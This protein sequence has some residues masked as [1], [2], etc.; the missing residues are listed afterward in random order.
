MEILDSFHEK[1]CKEETANFLSRIFFWWINPLINIG[2]QRFLQE[3][4]LYDIIA[5]E[6]I[7][8]NLQKFNKISS[9]SNTLFRIFFSLYKKEFFLAL[10]FNFI[11]SLLQFAGP[12]CLNQILQFLQENDTSTYVGYIWASIMVICFFLRS[13]FQQHA[14]HYMNRIAQ[15][16]QSSLYGKIYEKLLKLGTSSKKLHDTGKI[17]NMIN[18]DVYAIWNF[19]QF[20]LF[21]L[22]TPIILVL[23]IILIIMQLSWIGAIGI[24]ILLNGFLLQ[25]IAQ[26][27]GSKFRKNMMKQT[28]KRCQAIH[29]FVNGIK[30][31]KYFGWEKIALSR[32]LELRKIESSNIMSQAVL[33]GLTDVISTAFPLII[34]IVVFSIYQIEF[35]DLTPATAYTVLSLFNLI[36]VPLSIVGHLMV[37]YVNA[38]AGMIR[39]QRFINCEE[40]E[41]NFLKNDEK[42]ELKIGDI[43]IENG[44]FFWE[45]IVEKTIDTINPMLFSKNTKTRTLP[46]HDRLIT[47]T[48][49]KVGT[50]KKINLSMKAGEFFAVIGT[51]G[52]G[53]SSLA[54]CLLNEMI[55]T[56]GSLQYAGNIAYVPQ[57]AWLMNATFRENIL[58]YN[59]YDEIKY[60]KILNICKLKNDINMLPGGDLTEIGER[61]VNLSGGQKQ[62]ISLARALYH[63]ADIYIIDDVLSALDAHVG[64]HIYKHV[65]RG[66]LRVKTVIFITHALQYI[67]DADRI[68]VFRNGE[69]CQQGTFSSL[70]QCAFDS[71]FRK[72]SSYQALNNSYLQINSIQSVMKIRCIREKGENIIGGFSLKEEGRTYGLVP[73]RIYKLYLL[74]GGCCLTFTA[75]MMFFW[76]QGARFMNDWWLGVWANDQYF[77]PNENY[78]EIYIGLAVVGSI[79]VYFRSRIFF[80]YTLKIS[81]RFQNNLMNTIFKAPMCWFDE[82]PVG[83]ILSRTTKDQDNLDVNLPMTMQFCL[84]NILKIFGT[85]IIASIAM[86]LFLIPILFSFIIYCYLI[87]KY[88]RSSCEI[89]RIELNSRGPVNSFFSETSEG[90]YVIR[91]FKKE[92]LFFK[93]F[94]EKAE[95]YMVAVQNNMYAARWIGLRTD[96]FGTMLVAA[97][98]YF[99]V[100][101]KDFNTEGSNTSLIGFSM[102]WILLITQ[103]LNF[104]IRLMA[105]TENY[106]SSVEKIDEYINNTP[107]EAD[108]D[109]PKPTQEVWP[110]L[111]II[112]GENLCYKYRENLDYVVKNISFDI[113]S[114]EKIGIVGRTG[115]GKSTLTLGLLRILELAPNEDGI[116]GRILIDGEDI[117]KIGLH[118]LRRKITIIPQ[119]PMLFS[120]TIRS[121]LDPFN[122]YIDGSIEEALIK[123]KMWN[124]LGIEGLNTEVFDGGFNFSLGQKQLICI[125]RALIRKPKLLIMDEATANM[126]E[127]TDFLIQ[128]LIQNEFKETTVLTIAHR[129]NTIINYDRIMVFEQGKIVEFDT[130][131][132]LLET[133]HSV[134]ATLVKENG[135]QFEM[136][137][138]KLARIQNSNE[139][140][141]S[142]S[143]TTPIK[144]NDFRIKNFVL[145]TEDSD[146]IN[147]SLKNVLLNVES[148]DK[149]EIPNEF[150]YNSEFKK[151]TVK[152]IQVPVLLG[153]DDR[154]F[155]TSI[156]N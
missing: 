28:D 117:S 6:K 109:L 124:F 46:T 21:G 104:A 37:T 84:I 77:L 41:T 86:P 95:N 133:Y 113:K 132:K 1:I 122:E 71:E 68:L 151:H 140:D 2:N 59:E 129:I 148:S 55:K 36:Q 34:S 153:I 103:L 25:N 45:K 156:F 56:K 98:A 48:F 83:N 58:F 85:V 143:P 76:N 22:S 16:I 134:F 92:K 108:F 125:A 12:L 145:N 112:K 149:I 35:S 62:R 91:A 27:C 116:I 9:Y 40:K 88:L 52:S 138:K 105:D 135:K 60:Q 44:E 8:Y 107:K 154:V 79:F 67:K 63:D 118:N 75:F 78:I 130:P 19:C 102:A 81:Q 24:F 73:M 141:E 50:I 74:S 82:T 42:I 26:K 64:K 20:L 7:D 131:F 4:D 72:L 111:G 13:I 65:L 142:L 147:V 38:K 94:I 97:S 3:K 139:K 100:V 69:I 54:C 89:K 43:M 47:D 120:G 136:K 53:K 17:T 144:I 96:F 10:F 127:K 32:I 66:Y 155:E 99:A 110:S 23:S 114:F 51:I 18:L 39:I 49:N 70:N 93:T 31:I 14:N 126:D 5:S 15:R 152:H 121:N 90:L 101:S 80:G 128:K 29:E 119:D 115:S 146:K 123:V 30:I 150:G 106:M 137:M 11:S 61:G 57:S 33:K 87:K